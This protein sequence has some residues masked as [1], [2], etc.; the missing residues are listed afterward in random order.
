MS[1]PLQKTLTILVVEDD[2]GDFG[3]I[4]ANAR[5]AKLERGHDCLIWAK[6]LAEGLA[7]GRRH[8]ADVVLLDLS[9]PDLD[10]LATVKAM[11]AALPETAIVVLTGQD[12]DAL[13]AAALEAGAQ[14]YLVKSHFD[15]DALGRAVRHARV[16]NRLEQ[17]FL[18]HHQHLE[19]LVE[20]RTAALSIAKE[21][22]EAAN[23]AKSV[24]LANMSH[25]L[26]TPMNGI[27]G[28]TDLA[29]CRATD[30]KQKDHLD[31]VKLASQNLLAIINDILDIS[32]IEAERLTLEQID[33]KLG[34]VMGSLAG[35]VAQTAAEKGLQLSFEIDPALAHLQLQGD[36]LRLGQILLNLTGN[37]IKFTAAGSVTIRALLAEEQPGS[38]LLR[39]EV[40]DTGIGIAAADQQRIFAAFQQADGSL[41]RK[42]GGTGLGLAIC[43]RLAQLM[44]GDI[45]VAS[46]PSA[47]S[48][49]WFTARMK[50]QKGPPGLAQ[51]A[52]GG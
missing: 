11:R 16:R 34:E 23:R 18:Q 42:Y 49:F 4:R 10:G 40:Q 7:Q 24:F 28:M 19:D 41:T 51:P 31:K 37:A 13:S 45:G 26:R 29:L 36:P 15:H 27:M 30:P 20:Q 14:D 9:L 47:G 46:S 2:P 21:A 50:R 12:E 48:T 32:K 6:T 8:Q 43:K 1:E 39:F 3:L 38:V 22:A 33:F 44:A 25:E 5:L 35:L 17:Q 52:A